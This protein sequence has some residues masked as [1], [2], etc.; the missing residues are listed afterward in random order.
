MATAR[1]SHTAYA[2]LFGHISHAD[3]DSEPAADQLFVEPGGA[4]P[5]TT[6]C[7][8]V[9]IDGFTL[10]VTLNDVSIAVAVAIL[11]RRGAQPPSAVRPPPRSAQRRP[12]LSHKPVYTALWLELD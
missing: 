10:D 2:D 11:C 7:T 5:K 1:R 4:Y 3:A 9:T 8:T 12:A 6:I